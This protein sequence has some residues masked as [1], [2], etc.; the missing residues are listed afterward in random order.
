MHMLPLILTDCWLFRGL[1][2]QEI[3]AVLGC[4]AAQQHTYPKHSFIFHA[5]DCVTRA[6][7]VVRGELHIVREDV[8]GNRII[9]AVCRPADLFGEVFACLPDHTADVSVVATQ[10][11]E[12]LFLDMQHLLTTCSNGCR[13]HNQLIHNYITVLAQK[14]RMLSSKIRHCTQRTT[15]S[16][17]LSYLSEQ[18][19]AAGS[20][21]FR[22]PLNRQ[23]LADYLSVDR[24]AL[25]AELSRLQ[26]EGKLRFHRNQFTLLASTEGSGE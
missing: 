5:G 21:T 24:S 23:Q 10:D 3:S 16:K 14:N 12:I 7:I 2:A 6:G 13:F 15:R 1:D 22:I 9:Q 26:T 8:W 17:V 11:T 25:S 20:T 4:I 18:A 19:M